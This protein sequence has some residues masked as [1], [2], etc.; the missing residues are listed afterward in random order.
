MSRI[1]PTLAE[2]AASYELW[3]EYYDQ[4]AHDSPEQWEQLGQSA[5]VQI[6][7]DAFD[8]PHAEFTADGA[9]YPDVTI[10]GSR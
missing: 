10:D 4:D 6:L 1:S 9:D 7:R 8:D 3:G 5:R 2:I